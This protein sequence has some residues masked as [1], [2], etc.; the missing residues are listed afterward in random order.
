MKTDFTLK[1]KWFNEAINKS[2]ISGSDS[3]KFLVEQKYKFIKD[4]K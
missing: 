2:T 1:I 4:Y 3:Y